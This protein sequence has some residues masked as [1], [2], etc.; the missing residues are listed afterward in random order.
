MKTS[1]DKITP[2]HVKLTLNVAPEELKPYIDGAYKAIAGQ[3][4]VPGF[5]KG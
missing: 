3:V 1:V 2:T 5:R 4:Q